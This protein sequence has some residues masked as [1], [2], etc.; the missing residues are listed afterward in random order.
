MRLARLGA[1]PGGSLHAVVGASSGGV[2]NSHRRGVSIMVSIILYYVY[3]LYYTISYIYTLYIYWII[4]T[5]YIYGMSVDTIYIY[6]CTLYYIILY[7]RLY[8]TKSAP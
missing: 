2:H 3:T 7:Y 1:G 8:Y 5:I 6:Y 4:H